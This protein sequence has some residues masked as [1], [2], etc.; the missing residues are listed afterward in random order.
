M[1]S[2]F[3]FP[4]NPN[5]L[6]MK[7]LIKILRAL[8]ILVMMGA[9]N[10]DLQLTPESTISDASFWRTPEQ[11]DAFVTGIHARLRANNG[12]LQALGEMRSDIFGT[13]PPSASAFT[14]EATQ[15]IE[16]M[17]LQT[18]DLD[19]SGVSNFGG[20]YS[21][22]VQI[23]LLISK[24]ETDVITPQN[25]NHYL[26]IAYGLRAF[27][28]FHLLRSW[29]DV[30]IQTDPVISID[31]ANLAKPASP[32]TEVMALI[33][34]DIETSLAS[35]GD[36][37]SIRNS[38][39]FWSKAAT[40]MLKSEVY[41]W[42]SHRDGG[43]ADAAVAKAALTD[44]QANVPSLALQ[45]SFRNV[46]SAGNKGNSE[47]IFAIRYMNPEAAMGFV[48]NTFVPQTNLIANFYDSLENRKFNA[49][50]DNWGGLLRAP[51]KISTFRKFDDADTRKW[52]TVQP[53]YNLV[54]GNYV[55]AGSF[56]KKYEGEQVAGA[57]IYTNDFPVYRYAD[58]LLLMAEAK[59]VLGEDP[60][61]EINMVR[62]RAY[63]AAYDPSVYGYPNQPGDAD[64]RQA[65][66]EERLRE[67]IFEGKRWYD[68]R[69]LGDMYVFQHTS[70]EP[71]EADEL[72]WPVDRN[73]LTNNRSLEQNPGYASF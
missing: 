26:G 5:A 35:F 71:S 28:Y 16:R 48:A 56:V 70:L 17:W 21:N 57:R 41:L 29:G 22:I 47:I 63:G 73:S 69:R 64:A 14:G 52:A 53:A 8:L 20:F 30:I 10:D 66:L 11:F 24:A 42:S 32:Q 4:F 34:S 46:F 31:I 67:F 68:L 2:A 49:T 7:N 54:S 51:V 37:Y 39:G 45:T 19:N 72:L 58:L 12:A 18:L 25:K 55:I 38:K 65:L 23:N 61:A 1:S 13:D 27:Y 15:G 40:L 62:E 60:A 33:K 6:M 59:I 44:I 3:R 36:D 43:T 9:C 50:T